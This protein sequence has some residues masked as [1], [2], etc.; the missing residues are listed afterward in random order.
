MY[1]RR[2]KK[3]RCQDFVTLKDTGIGGKTSSVKLR[4]HQIHTPP[5]LNVG[6]DRAGASSCAVGPA[7]AGNARG[8][9]GVHIEQHRVLKARTEDSIHCSFA[10]VR[11]S[12][13]AAKVKYE[14][15]AVDPSLLN[16]AFKMFW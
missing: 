2:R 1:A 14:C 12:M 8:S 13:H 9:A 15:G 11:N 7:E 5:T 6:T 4:A 16:T 3:R 10:A